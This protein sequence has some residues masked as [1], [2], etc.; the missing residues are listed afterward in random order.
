MPMRSLSAGPDLGPPVRGDHDVHAVRETARGD[1]VHDLLERLELLAEDE[2]VVD[3]QEDVAETV[4]DLAA[5]SPRPVGGHRVEP[6]LEEQSLARVDDAV[7]LGD[8]PPDR[9]GLQPRRDRADVRQVAERRERPA[10]EVEAVELHL[11]RRVVQRE[12]A[13]QR[14]DHGALAALRRA[15][16]HRVAG[17]AGEVGH[18]RVAALVERPVHDPDRH[19]E[20]SVAR[21]PRDAEPT[22]RRDLEPGQQLVERRRVGQRRQPHGVGRRALPLHPRGP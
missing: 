7:H 1:L 20:R 17:G 15:D 5:R 12:R 2:R 10:T 11:G 4:V 3:H 16:D 21:R 14:A 19:G 8:E 9:V 18:E 6:V 22:V 13:D